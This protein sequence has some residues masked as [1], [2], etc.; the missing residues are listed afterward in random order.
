MRIG[1][2]ASLLLVV[3]GV[4]GAAERGLDSAQMRSW[5]IVCD[6]AAT[7]SAICGGE[8]QALFK[9]MTGAGAGGRC[10]VAHGGAVFIG[11]TRWRVR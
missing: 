6:P 7:E 4:A 5:Q 3:A 8:F 10:G 11:R 2:A 9:G 1:F